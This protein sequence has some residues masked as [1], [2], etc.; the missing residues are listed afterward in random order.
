MVDIAIKPPPRIYTGEPEDL[1][2]EFR[3]ELT[4]MM[5]A[6]ALRMSC[7]VELLKYRVDNNGVV[8]IQKMEPDEAK[9]ME[10]ARKQNKLRKQIM[11]AKGN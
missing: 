10:L 7:P 5:K 3:R 6:A 11:K 1:A 2:E 8:E 9:A 4:H